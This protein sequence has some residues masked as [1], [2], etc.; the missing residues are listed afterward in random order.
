MFVPDGFTVPLF[1]ETEEFRLEPLGPEHNGRD[2]AAWSSSI[3][4][5]LGSPGYGPESRWPH[6]MSLEENLRDLERHARDFAER[7]GFTYTVLDSSHDVVGCV[8]VYPARDDVHDVQVQSWVRESRAQ[9]DIPLREAVAAWLCATGRSSGRSTSLCSTD[10]SGGE[11]LDVV[12]RDLRVACHDREA[13]ELGLRHE[14]PVERIPV[15]RGQ[16]TNP[17]SVLD[18]YCERREPLLAELIDEI[19]RHAELPNRHFHAQ[20]QR[21]NGTDENGIAWVFERGACFGSEL[22][23]T[24]ERPQQRVCIEEEPQ[25]SSS[26]SSP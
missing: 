20:L 23:G 15:V 13:F 4:H 8:Y 18:R 22:A 17:K 9:L 7:T 12:E 3:E 2:Y 24:L 26:S 16:L 10:C 25:A 5:I 11:R 1:L 19:G 21:R 6:A 14:Q